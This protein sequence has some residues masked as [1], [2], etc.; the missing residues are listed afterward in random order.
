TKDLPIPPLLL[1]MKLT[2][3]DR[4]SSKKLTHASRHLIGCRST[5]AAGSHRQRRQ[6]EQ[7]AILLETAQIACTI[8]PFEGHAGFATKTLRSVHRLVW[9]CPVFVERLG[10]GSV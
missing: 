9:T 4:R 6:A 1:R 10:V 2:L 5:H 8:L 7:Q 3:P